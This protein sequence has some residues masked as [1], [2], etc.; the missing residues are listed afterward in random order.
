MDCWMDNEKKTTYFGLTVHY[1]STVD[2]QIVLNDRVLLIRELSAETTK[3]G[4]YLRSKI[5]EYL[6]EF[7]LLD[8]L[9]KK[10]IFISDRGT[11]MVS[12]VRF[13]EN[14]HCFAHLLNNT[15]SKVFKKDPHKSIAEQSWSFC[16]VQAVTAIVK[17]FKSSALATRF[18]PTLKSNVST[19]WNSVYNMLESFIHHWDLINEILHSTKKHLQDLNSITLNEL[20][21]LRDFLKPFKT[22]TDELEASKHPTLCHVIPHYLK[23]YNHLQPSPADPNCI[24][25]SKRIALTYWTENV[26]K[27]LTTHHGIALFLHPLTK[28]LKTQ[29]SDEKNEIWSRTITLMNEFMPENSTQQSQAKTPKTAKHIDAALALCMGDSE[30]DEE[31]KSEVQIELDDYK[32]L[33]IRGEN[34]H[35]INNLLMWWHANKQRF[36]RL[37]G[38]ARFVLSIP[39]SSAAAERLFSLAGRLVAFR[40]NMRS[41]LVDEMLFLKSNIDL[42]RHLELREELIEDSAIET[43]SLENDGDDSDV[44]EI[45]VDVECDR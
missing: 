14:I 33:R 19:R 31:D 30:S 22:S 26:Q 40:P 13:Y 39:A 29:T 15:L 35:D 27:Q 41:D 18:K 7:D 21:I 6:T 4:E 38:V 16:K 10:L 44:Q 2:D 25:E 43:I 11:N 20:E 42:S 17:Y 45:L 12:S 36:P 3:S 24:A 5:I 34:A 28:H 37:Y 1:T 8:C 23:I 32:S 9:E